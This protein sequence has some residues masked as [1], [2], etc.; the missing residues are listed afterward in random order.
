MKEAAEKIKPYFD[1]DQANTIE[2][3]RLYRNK[4]LNDPDLEALNAALC[5]IYMPRGKVWLWDT[6]PFRPYPLHRN[7]QSMVAQETNVYC[8]CL[9]RFVH[10]E[11]RRRHG[12][13]DTHQS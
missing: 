8:N 12:H 10:I 1:F 2:V 7:A 11:I 6:E 5:C 9:V 3:Y 4:A 13:S